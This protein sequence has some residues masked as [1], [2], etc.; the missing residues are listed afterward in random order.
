M[1]YDDD[2]DW[3]AAGDAGDSGSIF[4]SILSFMGAAALFIL[5]VSFL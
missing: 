5:I 3:I 4:G 2:Y 1:Y